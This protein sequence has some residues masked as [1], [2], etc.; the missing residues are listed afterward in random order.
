[1]AAVVPV[2]ALSC[3]GSR[4]LLASGPSDGDLEQPQAE[5]KFDTKVDWTMRQLFERQYSTYIDRMS[6]LA[7][8]IGR[9]HLLELLKKS[10]ESFYRSRAP[11]KPGNTLAAFVKPFRENDYYKTIMTIEFLED[12]ERA[13]SWRLTEC[14]HA[15]IFREHN[16]A[17][18]GFATLCHGDEA[19]V[20]AYN[21]SIRFHRTKT[22]MEGH[23]CCDHRYVLVG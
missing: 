1:M 17:D 16:A 4:V 10:T 14:L 23:D 12:T 21:P 9:D 19:W 7:E 22:L 13:V 6:R 8:F 20:T 5:H 3:I 2:C 18:I 11:Y 15:T